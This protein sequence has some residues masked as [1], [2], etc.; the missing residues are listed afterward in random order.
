M[1]SVGVINTSFLLYLDLIESLSRNCETFIWITT[2]ANLE[3]PP[4]FIQHSST[5]TVL[6]SCSLTP[7]HLN[8]IMALPSLYQEFI[9]PLFLDLKKN[10]NLIETITQ[11][12]AWHSS[13]SSFYFLF[14]PFLNIFM[15]IFRSLIV[16]YLLQNS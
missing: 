16:K 11:A 13:S 2:R 15:G 4:D 14:F 1:S 12:W 10:F 6:I 9:M 3:F 8:F 5:Y 7:L